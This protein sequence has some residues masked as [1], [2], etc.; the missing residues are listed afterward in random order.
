V[1]LAQASGSH[2]PAKGGAVVPPNVRCVADSFGNYTCTDGSRIL[3]D[4]FG[5]VTVIPGRK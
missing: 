1:M 2:P 4:S 3:R 5:N